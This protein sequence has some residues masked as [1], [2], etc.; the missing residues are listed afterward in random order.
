MKE[1][2]AQGERRY[3][4]CAEARRRLAEFQHHARAQDRGFGCG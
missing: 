4:L 3:Q 1:L 2:F